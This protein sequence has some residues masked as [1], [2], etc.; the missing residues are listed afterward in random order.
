MDLFFYLKKFKET[1]RHNLII[2]ISQGVKMCAVQ[3]TRS[4]KLK[5]D[6]KTQQKG[7]KLKFN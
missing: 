1:R 5:Y 4:V 2:H 7:N 6:K 3:L